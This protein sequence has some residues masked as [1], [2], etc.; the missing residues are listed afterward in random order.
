[1][2]LKLIGITAAASL[3]VGCVSTG[4]TENDG[5]QSGA[6]Y[7]V[8]AS[9]NVISTA[10]GQC[11]Q[12]ASY[13]K[14]MSLLD[15][16]PAAKAAAEKAAAEKKAA[17]IAAA[18]KKAAADAAAEKKAAAAD[19]AAAAAAAAASTKDPIPMSISGEALFA[20]GSST[21]SSKEDTALGKLINHLSKFS[22]IDSLTVT[23]HTD[24]QGSDEL[25]KSLSRNRANTVRDEIVASGIATLSQ[26]TV[27]GM[28]EDNPI[29]SNDTADGRSQNRRV[30]IEVRGVQ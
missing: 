16:D 10:S 19:A 11:I 25:N 4:S 26:I 18:E 14:D 27:I 5:I 12:S 29:A 24:S 22:K 8:N 7:L 3:I 2:I 20:S 17:E 9:G 13:N 21:L 15:C 30:E 1:M 28:G 23:G 6:G